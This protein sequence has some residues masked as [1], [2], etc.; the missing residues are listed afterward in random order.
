MQQQQVQ[1]VTISRIVAGNNPRGYFDEA[2]MKE[3]ENSVAEHGII[4]PI[5]LRPLEGDGDRFQIIAGER[6]YRAAK[7]VFGDAYQIPALCRTATQEEADQ[8]AL[9]ENIQRANMS[10]TEEAEAAAKILGQNN[11]DKTETARLL[12]WTTQKLE[13]R[14]ALMNCS[15][16]VRDALNKRQ[17][18]LGHAELLASAPKEKQDIV[19][20][21]LLESPTLVSVAQFKAGL[22]TASKELATAIFPKEECAS[23]FHRSENQ[24]DLFS[25][26]ISGGRC[27]NGACFEKKTADA[28]NDLKAKLEEEYPSVRIVNAGDNNT[29]V[30]LKSD[31][32]DGVGDVQ[33][34]ACRGCVNFGAAI[35][36]VP[37]K[38]GNVRRDI[39][40]DVACNTQKVAANIKAMKASAATATA[41]A[42]AQEQEGKAQAATSNAASVAT[43]KT[44]A[45]VQVSQRIVEYRINVWR[46]AIKKELYV[47]TDK[48]MSVLMGALMTVGGNNI[49][50]TKLSAAFT[51]LSGLEIRPGNVGSAAQ[52]FEVPSSE[53]RHQMLRGVVMSIMDN[54]EPRHLESIMAFLQVDLKKYWTLNDE[55]LNLLTKSEIEVVAEELGLKAAMGEKYAKAASSKKDEFI[56][57]LLQ[58]DGFNYSGKVVKVLQYDQQ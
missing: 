32:A 44:P 21:K 10:P 51:K 50:A 55:Y 27:T 31:G 57:S 30:I 19:V 24:Q 3:L 49:S 1:Y 58:I 16:L 11:G 54:I 2:E 56:K 12:A 43:P 39:C 41:K 22:E 13:K 34:K 7:K 9:V 17:I 23:C 4:Q 47:D 36:N 42:S 18:L 5:L 52:M 28:L 26:A 25:E 8:M 53:I 33:A 6:R 37:G 46:S 35:S 45:T 29:L 40:F 14:L 38:V 48:N 15:A 20:K